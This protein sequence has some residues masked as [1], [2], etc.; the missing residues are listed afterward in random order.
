MDFTRESVAMIVFIKQRA[1]TVMIQPIHDCSRYRPVTLIDIPVPMSA[2]AS[3]VNARV[4]T[5]F[6]GG[7]A[8]ASLE[9]DWEVICTLV[10]LSRNGNFLEYTHKR[11][12]KL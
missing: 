1:T 4:N 2:G 10:M 3:D 6:D 7:C 12:Q 5:G 11:L 9:I 8:L